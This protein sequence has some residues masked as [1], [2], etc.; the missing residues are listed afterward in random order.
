MKKV[1]LEF[2]KAT[3]SKR[4]KNQK[5]V[6]SGN[7]RPEDKI[8]VQFEIDSIPEN[9]PFLLSRDL[10]YARPSGSEVE[11]FQVSFLKLLLTG[12]VHPII[13]A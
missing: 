6:N 13:A 10:V 8:F 5:N 3:V 11:P 2:H 12:T 4:H 1:T 9:R 7:D